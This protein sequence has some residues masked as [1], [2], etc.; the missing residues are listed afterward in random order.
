[1]Y[2]STADFTQVIAHTPL[3]SIDLVVRNPQ[4]QFLFGWRTNR[5][6]KNHWFVP[7][8]RIQKDERLESAF[9]R[10]TK[11][12]LGLEIPM[13]KASWKGLYQ[14]FYDD[15]VFADNSTQRVSTH[16]VVL[17]FEVPLKQMVKDLPKAQHAEYQWMTVPEI[18]ENPQVHDY[19]RAYFT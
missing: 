12:E 11:A 6:A 18:L 16:Y 5:P 2:L 17:A 9:L 13:P 8:G 14:H 3:V 15:F 4:G 19:S 1:M 7:G 10:L